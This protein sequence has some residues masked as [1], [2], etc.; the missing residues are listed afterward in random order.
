[1]KVS[2]Y[3]EFGGDCREAFDFYARATGGTVVSMMTFGETPACEH[4]PAESRQLIMHAALRL[5]SHFIMASDSMPGQPYQGIKGASV[6]LH[7][8]TPAEADRVFNHLAEG[9][10]VTMPI[11]RTFWAERF[12]MLVD[13]FGVPWIINCEGDR[14]NCVPE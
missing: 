11:D 4:V 12:G 10:Q 2:P 1:M 14:G 7:P 3:L 8:E 6:S 9:G 13:R 5:G